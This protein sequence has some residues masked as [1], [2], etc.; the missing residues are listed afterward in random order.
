MAACWNTSWIYLHTNATDC[1]RGIEKFHIP[2]PILWREERG[3]NE[4]QAEDDPQP[5]CRQPRFEWPSQLGSSTSQQEQT[6]RNS[7]SKPLEL[8]ALEIENEAVDVFRRRK[9]DS[10][11]RGYVMNDKT[12]QWR[13]ERT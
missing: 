9:Q 6:E 10:K 8:V 13:V 7:N 11:Q 2:L 3:H 4:P 5:H 1:V 12:A